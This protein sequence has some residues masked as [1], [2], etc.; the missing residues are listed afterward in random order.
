MSLISLDELRT[1][2]AQTEGPSISI[3]MPTYRASAEV[4]QN[5]IRFKNLLRQAE[6]DL[7][8]RGLRSTEINNLLSSA[9]NLD[10]LDFWEH[11]NEGLA[12]FLAPNFL[13]YYRLPMT[14]NE[15]VVVNDRFHLKPIMPF[16]VGDGEF[17]ILS[18]SQNGLRFLEAS[19]YNVQEVEVEGMP[20]SLDE[21]LQYDET[22]KDGQFR[23]GTTAGNMA[24]HHAGS[25]QGTY[26]AGT[27][28][29]QGS[30]DRDKHQRDILQFFHQVDHAVH[31]HLRSKQAPL[32]LVGVDYLLPLYR[33]ANNYPH[34]LE[35]GITENAKTLTP[36]EIHGQVLPLVEP[37]FEHDREEAIAHYHELTNTGR[38]ST[39]LK[40]AVSGAYFGRIEQL[41]VAVGVQQWGIFDADSN[42]LLVHNEAEPGDEDLLNTAAIQTL[43]NG[44]TVYA[45]PPDQ[46]P[47]ATLLAAVFRY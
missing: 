4:L 16:L 46:V 36:E 7:Q 14:F 28:H 26:H 1:L 35:E 11:Q 17:Y 12:L 34:L 32:V 27:F 47:N 22:A 41:F 40:E 23:L 8:N 37:Y 24:T 18:L 42:E 45:V 10:H 43:L 44:G 21:A 5:P 19:R 31:Q 38:T 30:P 39:D 6:A 9:R 20:K 33:E 2:A 29:G 25:A 13:R 15:M 3:F